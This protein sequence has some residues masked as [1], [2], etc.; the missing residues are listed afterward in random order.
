MLESRRA[1][2]TVLVG[3]GCVMLAT[4]QACAIN[5]LVS[6][7]PP[8]RPS[9]AEP[10]SLDRGRDFSSAARQAY[11]QK[12]SDQVATSAQLSSG[13]I[14]LGAVVLALAAG[15]AHR[16][17][18]LGTTLFGA[19][20]FALGSWNLDKR[21]LLIYNGAISAFNCADRA[22]SPLDAS[23]E[24]LV[25]LDTSL[26]ALT[27]ATAGATSAADLV[28]LQVNL[29]VSAAPAA[30]KYADPYNAAIASARQAAT[31]AMTVQAS[32]E[33]LQFQSAH[34]SDRLIDA[35][36]K[37]DQEANAALPETVGDLNK[38]PSVIAGLAG[39]AGSIA[40]GSNVEALFNDALKNSVVAPKTTTPAG[41]N[42]A[43]VAES[44]PP[45]ALVEATAEMTNAVR[46]LYGAASLVLGKVKPLGDAFNANALADC[47]IGP[48]SFAMSTSPAKLSAPIS[49]KAEY[50]VT[51]SGGKAPYA[52]KPNGATID[53]VSVSGPDRFGAT[54]D[55]K[56]AESAGK[57]QT[58]NYIIV[59][60]SDPNRTLAFSVELV[61]ATGG[62]GNAPKVPDVPKQPTAKA[63]VPPVKNPVGAPSPDSPPLVAMRQAKPFEFAGVQLSYPSPPRENK[64]GNF[65]VTLAC[66]PTPPSCFKQ[67][68]LRKA[69]LPNAGPE[70]ATVGDKL[71][72]E[73]FSPGHCVCP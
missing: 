57:A 56:V 9:N 5:P 59:D 13:L 30:A 45:Q 42:K 41:Q 64:G 34:A 46:R 11:Q 68:D 16:D 32:G 23:H 55:V 73:G 60:S 53:G 27:A 39:I 62:S 19:T 28:Q 36:R 21:R 26:K 72:F 2:K 49:T 40:P 54:F 22:V 24:E 48:I 37:I 25:S 43:L 51:I 50:A 70:A 63:K 8:A 7:V 10:R 33:A 12:M 44:T 18:I 71:M 20:S 31:A 15:G 1:R 69:F 17:A 6:W 65:I 52:V 66:K 29:W 4:L 58:A 14:G 38:V 3:A 61:G 67:E 47:G 35:V